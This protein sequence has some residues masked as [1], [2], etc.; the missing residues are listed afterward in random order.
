MSLSVHLRPLAKEDVFTSCK[1]RN[2]PSLW[3]FIGG[4]PN[5]VVTEEIELEWFCRSI[6]D[7]AWRG[8]AIVADG[9]YIGNVELAGISAATQDAEFR[10][11]IG[12]TAFAGRGAASA[13]TRQLAGFARRQLHLARLFLNVDRSHAIATRIYEEAGF[14]SSGLPGRMELDL[15]TTSEPMVSVFML[16]YNHEPYIRQ[17]LDSVLGQN[18]PFPVEIMIGEDFSQD[19]TRAILQEY[20]N[21]HPTLIRVIAHE[22]N[23]G[24][25]RNHLVTMMACT[26]RY[27]A[28]LEGDDYW[29]NKQKLLRQVE[30][31]ER[32][33]D[34][35][36]CFHAVSLLNSGK[37]HRDDIT[38]VPAVET[39]IYDLAKGNYIHTPSVMFRN[40]VFGEF[41]EWFSDCPVGDY[42]LHLL[43]A[44]HG[45]IL[46]LDERMAVYRMHDG[47]MWS[48]LSG[49]SRL[50]KWK[51]TQQILI[52]KFSPDVD[53]ILKH[54][55]AE[56]FMSL[57]RLY[58]MS[59]DSPRAFEA[60]TM[61][62]ELNPAAV[63][64]SIDAASRLYSQSRDYRL[65]HRLLSIP[66]TLLRRWQA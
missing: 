29:T 62:L 32:R 10:I 6:R 14:K 42:P 17:A 41:P 12:D 27:V 66:R 59:G 28:M 63:C 58:A 47:S 40:G 21:A 31:L 45:N 53:V 51:R 22:R 52:G 35:A 50:E 37:L 48:S 61:A 38:S 18:T 8:F 33:P 19:R 30:I 54:G 5:R 36:I 65:G 39:N 2:D 23:V 16:A 44:L 43:N 11:L 4:R 7:K 57:H 56:T 55:L 64:E 3:Q 49:V 34:V 13:A 26:G 25:M 15:A 1:W 9:R 24:A 60:V 46:F 20:Q